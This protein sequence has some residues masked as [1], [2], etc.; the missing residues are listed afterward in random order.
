MVSARDKIQNGKLDYVDGLELR[1]KIKDSIMYIIILKDSDD[2]CLCHR[3]LNL[4]HEAY[5][6]I[7]SYL[8]GCGYTPD[9]K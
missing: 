1:S 9:H 6:C 7:L 4:L 5:K 3:T 8:D 2:E